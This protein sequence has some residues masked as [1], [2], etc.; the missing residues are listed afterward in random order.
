MEVGEEGNSEEDRGWK[1]HLRIPLSETP[2]VAPNEATA[3]EAFRHLNEDWSPRSSRWAKPLSPSSVWRIFRL[4]I[5]QAVFKVFNQPRSGQKAGQFYILSSRK[6]GRL[7]KGEIEERRG[8][9]K[10][11]KK[12]KKRKEKKK[13]EIIFKLFTSHLN[14][15]TN[16]FLFTFPDHGK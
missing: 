5:R 9:K 7:R 6:V 16:Y 10:K 13:K 4:I 11:K 3:V 1:P 15:T 2:E 8:R 12:K 14:S